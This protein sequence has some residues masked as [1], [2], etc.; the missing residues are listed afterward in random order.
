MSYSCVKDIDKSSL[1]IT[2]NISPLPDIPLSLT[3][4]LLIF[5]Y[6]APVLA[7]VPLIDISPSIEYSGVFKVIALFKVNF[8]LRTNLNLSSNKFLCA[9]FITL[10]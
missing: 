8:V 7:P 9:V 1:L 2:V 3:V 4:F 10:G 5:K 6:L